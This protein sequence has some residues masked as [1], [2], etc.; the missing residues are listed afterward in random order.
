MFVKIFEEKAHAEAFIRGDLYMQTLRMFK[1]HT[2]KSGELRGD[3]ME[4][5]VAWYQ[6]ESVK[7]EINGQKISSHEISAPIGIHCSTLLESN[8]FCLYSLNSSGHET[9]SAPTL[10]DF[11]RVLEIHQSCYGLGSYCVAILNATEFINRCK[12]AL[13][14]LDSTPNLLKTNTKLGKV[15]YF[16]ELAENGELPPEMNGF[17]KRSVYGNQREYRILIG[18]N[19]EPDVYSLNVGDLSDITS[20]IITP[21]DF[22][23]RLEIKLPDG[24]I[25]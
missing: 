15:R 7:L 1:E 5:V 20:E 19:R 25:A 13:T 18:L 17:H 14:I 4:G 2:D 11:K 21:D 23:S 24:S 12:K 9:I 16:N 3:P 8:A 10:P 6:P 22:N